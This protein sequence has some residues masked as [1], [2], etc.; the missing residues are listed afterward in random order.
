M[1]VVLVGAE[2]NA[3]IQRKASSGSST[4]G[5]TRRSRQAKA[6]TFRFDKIGGDR[7]LILRA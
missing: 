1:I 5:P 4:L 7:A 3:E 6:Y 2:G